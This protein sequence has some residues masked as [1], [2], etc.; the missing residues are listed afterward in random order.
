MFAF[1]NVRPGNPCP[2]HQRKVVA[3]GAMTLRAT[4]KAP[5]LSSGDADA[6]SRAIHGDPFSVLGPHDTPGGLVIRA[7]VPGARA[8]EVL[9]REGRAIL[10]R[11]DEGDPPGLF[12]G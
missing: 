9:R 1:S 5:P 6:F 2:S 4:I 10:G 7:F 11:L 12:Q 3:E 8:V